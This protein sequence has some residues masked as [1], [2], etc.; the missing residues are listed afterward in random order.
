MKFTKVFLGIVLFIGF[1]SCS[2]DDALNDVEQR[3][4]SYELIDIQ[5][6]LDE[7]DGE[8][9]VENKIPEFHFRND[10]DTIME[11]IIEPLKNIQGSSIFKFND[12]LAF[13]EIIYT[14]V[15]VSIPRELSLLSQEYSYLNG[16]VKVAFTQE[17]SLFPFSW[18]FTDSFT[19]SKGTKLTSNYTVFLRKNKATFVAT[20]KETTTGETLE[21]EGTWTGMFFNNIEEKSVLEEIDPSN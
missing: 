19:L 6:K 11:V 1:A 3:S 2:S 7:T 9:I 18:N 4:K 20:F 12:S 17:E 5:W 15:K 8:S 10:S 21:L 14:E 16:G 13:E